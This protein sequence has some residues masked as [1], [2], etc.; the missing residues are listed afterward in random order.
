MA[1]TFTDALLTRGR[2]T[3]RGRMP[4]ASNATF[5]AELE[6]DGAA[7]LAVYKPGRGERPLWDFPPGLFARE[8]AAYQLSEAL[9]WGLVPPTVRREG[10]YGEGSLQLFV[11]ADFEQHYFTLRENPAHHARLKRI[12]VFDVVANNADRKAGHCLLAPDGAIF[13]VDNG[14]CFHVE[15]KLR[16]VIWDFG[17]EPIPEGLGDDLRRFAAAPL[18]DAL[19]ALLAPAECR[20]LL[21]RAHALAQEGRFPT[22]ASGVRYPWPLV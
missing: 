19:A 17:G 12:C 22:D 13:A 4:A 15:P 1:T 20:A 2:I 8:L 21:A 6:L 5:L 9:G 18:P 7:G 3:L 16:T 11:P 10:P 14:L